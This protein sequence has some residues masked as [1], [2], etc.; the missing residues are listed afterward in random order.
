MRSAVPPHWR[1]RYLDHADEVLARLPTLMLK[2]LSTLLGYRR[3]RACAAVSRVDI[4]TFTYH[5]YGLRQDVPCV[6]GVE[7]SDL[8][9]TG[10]TGRPVLLAWSWSLITR[11]RDLPV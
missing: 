3:G 5:R 2:L 7:C 4:E 11:Q 1:D 8:D 6:A 9:H 10:T